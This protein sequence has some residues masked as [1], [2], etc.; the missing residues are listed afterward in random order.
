MIPQYHR[1]TGNR[2]DLLT[3]P[4]SCFSDLT[5]SMNSVKVRLHLGKTPMKSDYQAQSKTLSFVR[6]SHRNLPLRNQ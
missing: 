5:N 3:D 2:E 6:R 1:D 4:N